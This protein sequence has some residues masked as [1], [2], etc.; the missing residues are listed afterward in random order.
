MKEA[1]PM[2]RQNTLHMPRNVQRRILVRGAKARAA[3]EK[4]IVL[5]LKKNGTPSIVYGLAEYLEKQ[6]LPKQVKPWEYRH[7]NDA[8][9]DPLGAQDGTVIASLSRS[10]IYE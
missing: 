10:D 8:T 3:G 9:P 1:G 2:K 4:A 7:A 6:Q 5:T